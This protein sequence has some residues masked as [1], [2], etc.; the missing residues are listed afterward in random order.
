MAVNGPAAQDKTLIIVKEDGCSYCE[1]AIRHVQEWQKQEEKYLAVDVVVIDEEAHPDYT[2]KNHCYVF[3][4]FFAGGVKLY[5]GIATKEVV[6]QILEIVL[7]GN[8]QPLELV[9]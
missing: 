5:E 2:E 6:R 3:P 1:H 8:F 9:K 4:S 7:S